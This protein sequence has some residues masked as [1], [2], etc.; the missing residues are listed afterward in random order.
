MKE[1]K[2][3][4]NQHLYPHRYKTEP[5]IMAAPFDFR[6]KDLELH[7]QNV[8]DIHRCA[9]GHREDRNGNMFRDT[10]RKHD[11]KQDDTDRNG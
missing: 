5:L 1:D 4:D 10:D 2:E 9:D 3:D 11:W 6:E 7:E 8:I